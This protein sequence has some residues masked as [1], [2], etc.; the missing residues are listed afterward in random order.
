[1]RRPIVVALMAGILLVACTDQPTEAPSRPEP[2]AAPQ[3]D[4]GT[5]PCSLND[6][7]DATALLFPASPARTAIVNSL[8]ALSVARQTRLA[9]L[10]KA[11]A[12]GIVDVVGKAYTAG[13]LVNSPNT[14]RNVLNFIT[15]LY[16]FTGVLPPPNFPSGPIDPNEFAVAVVTPNSGPVLVRPNSR[17]GGISIQG[18]SVTTTTTVTVMKL[19]D[20]PGPL[21]TSLDQFPLFYE[22]RTSPEVTFTKDVTTGVCLGNNFPVSSAL[23]LAHNVGTNFGN[24]EIL[25]FVSPPFLDCTNI[26]G[27]LGSLRGFQGLFA[28]LLLPTELHAASATMVVTTKVGGTL[29]HLSPFGSVDPGSNPGSLNYNP[30]EAAFGN[31]TAAPGGNV[32]PAPSVRV[33]SQNGT[34]IQSVPVVFAVTAGGGSISGG[35]TSGGTTATV[36]TNA[37]GIA[38]LTNWT[39]GP[40]PGTNTVSATPP[41]G[42]QV[43]T[44]PPFKPA[45]AFSPA[46]LTFTAEAVGPLNYGATGFRY[47]FPDGSP[48]SGFQSTS[49]NDSSWLI[50]DAAFGFDNPTDECF[51][52]EN[53]SVNTEWPAN[54]QILL[55]RRFTLP[56]GPSTGI[57][58]VAIDNDLKVFVNGIDITPTAESDN[59]TAVN[60]DDDGFVLHEG[61][62]T[63]GSFTFTASSLNPGVNLLVIEARDR[64]GSTY[65]DAEVT[66]P[67]F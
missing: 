62:P 21:L 54:S 12:F 6:L 36:F 35:T 46:S 50:G 56:G 8:K 15:T 40:E 55:R 65:I 63:R 25:P 10:I 9:N 7:I 61:C 37:S 1:M 29:R 30:N 13:K 28:S 14:P 66:Q 67:S 45:V 52:I 22:F 33:T 34:P 59:E 18:Q 48:P 39:L 43:G 44:T 47:F 16:C 26:P 60:F 17:H 41:A 32:S 38:S 5:H 20:A 3:L 57:V 51:L 23:R 49:F 2:P 42:A 31:L 11:A 19:P 58:S 27:T 64:G 24:V 53:G 4:V